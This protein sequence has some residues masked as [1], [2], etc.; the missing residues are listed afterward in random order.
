MGSSSEGEEVSGQ[1]VE[2]LE[3]KCGQAAH[4]KDKRD[5][6]KW[7]KDGKCA[8]PMWNEMKTTLPRLGEF[9]QR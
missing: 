5:G 9:C 7:R 6:A 8:G 1:V 4:V 2:M 3:R